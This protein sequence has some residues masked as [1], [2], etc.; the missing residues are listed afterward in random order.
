MAKYEIEDWQVAYNAAKT[1]EEREKAIKD[2][3]A[4]K[5]RN[6][7]RREEERLNAPSFID[8]IAAAIAKL[9]KRKAE[10]KSKQN[11]MPT[12]DKTR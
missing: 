5:L 2:Y 9:S 10:T 1:E 6:A 11:T 4:T 3:E 7:A 8:K 12:N